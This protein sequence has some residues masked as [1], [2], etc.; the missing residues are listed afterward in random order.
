MRSTFLLLALSPSLGAQAF[1]EVTTEKSSYFVQERIEVRLRFGFETPFIK[2]HLIQPGQK[3]LDVPGRL[4]APWLIELPG[5]VPFGA[6]ENEPSG[7]DDADQL[8]FV[9]NDN[10]AEAPGIEERRNGDTPFTVVEIRRH[11]MAPEPGPI[12]IPAPTL[13]YAYATAFVENFLSA[14]VPKD[15]NDAELVGN[16][17]RLEIKPL[18]LDGQP[19]NFTGAVGRFT[20]RAETAARNLEVRESFKL[21]LHIEGEGNMRSLGAPTLSEL[22]GFHVF[23]QIDDIGDTRTVT[24]DLAPISADVTEIPAIDLAFFDPESSEYESVSTE[25]IPLSV[26]LGAPAAATVPGEDDIYDIKPVAGSEPGRGISPAIVIAVLLAPW[27]AVL[28][29]LYRRR[30]IARN[31]IDPD[32]LRARAAAATF[33]QRIGDPDTK[34]DQALAEFL[35]AH[36]R[37]P[38]AAVIAPDL[39]RRLE[40]SGIPTALAQDTATF[41]DD[42]V[43]ARFGGDDP[44]S[45]TE[46]ARELV[47]ALHAAFLPDTGQ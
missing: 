14:R 23:G 27:L 36:L 31:R 13:R 3:S 45:G 9:L 38:A 47:A 37:I 20:V 21:E 43:D 6:L 46:T 25:P 18:P 5:V 41:L 1:V 4:E 2:D 26:T 17:L 29:V 40:S 8:T 42:L 44:H 19:D 35:A 15:R 32:E 34:L 10:P 33:H 30:V 28:G 22:T 16:S 39:G 24:Y 12:E 7:T 11:Y